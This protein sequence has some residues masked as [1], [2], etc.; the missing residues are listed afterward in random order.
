V[1]VKYLRVVM[2]R[3]AVDEHVAQVGS[4]ASSREA[5]L[6]KA[7][8]L[9]RREEIA[10]ADPE[11]AVDVAYRMA[12]C[13]LARQVMYGPTFESQRRVAWDDLVREI[14]AACT[15]YLLDSPHRP[16]RESN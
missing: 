9:T 4:A 5:E 15:S 3:G 10:H 13:T 12:Y 16:H 8:L 2:H 11:L 7:L 1:H 14:G 6:F